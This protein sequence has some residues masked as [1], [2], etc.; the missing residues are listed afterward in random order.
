VKQRPAVVLSSTGYNTERPDLILIAI[1]SEVRA[2]AT[3]D[4]VIVQHWQAR[5]VRTSLARVKLKFRCLRHL[6]RH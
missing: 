3:F 5:T 1:S 2:P 6:W 4:E